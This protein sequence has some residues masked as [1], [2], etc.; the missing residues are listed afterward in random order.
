MNAA[1]RG[2]AKLPQLHRF[3]K[4]TLNAHVKYILSTPTNKKY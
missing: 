3:L 2:D 4:D 1:Q